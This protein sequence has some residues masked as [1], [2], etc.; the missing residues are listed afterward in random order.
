M[1]RMLK[2]FEPTTLP[3]AMS[4]WRRRAAITE[5]ANSGMLVPADTTVRPM[6][7]SLTPQSRAMATAETTNRRDP[8]T[9]RTSPATIRKISRHTDVV[10]AGRA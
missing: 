5:V 8:A 9:R 7:A 1:Q 10:A 2:I 6:T 4:G 3:T